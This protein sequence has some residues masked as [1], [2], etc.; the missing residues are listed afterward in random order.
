MIVGMGNFLND[1]GGSNILDS[2]LHGLAGSLFCCITV[3][4]GGLGCI[5]VKVLR[6]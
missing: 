2:K 5:V 3:V 1:L 6:Y 4:D